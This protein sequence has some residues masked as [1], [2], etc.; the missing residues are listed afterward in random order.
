MIWLESLTSGK[1]EWK[2]VC[3]ESF[4]SV[5]LYPYHILMLKKQVKTNLV[6]SILFKGHFQSMTNFSFGALSGEDACARV[7]LVDRKDGSLIFTGKNIV[8]GICHS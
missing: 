5:V 1:L 6:K 7:M 8:S 2:R 4:T 3:N